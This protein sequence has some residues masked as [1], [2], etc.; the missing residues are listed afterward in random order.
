MLENQMFIFC[1][2]ELFDCYHFFFYLAGLSSFK[3][4]RCFSRWT[5]S[6]D[7]SAIEIDQV[8]ILMGKF[9][10]ECAFDVFPTTVCVLVL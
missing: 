7:C 2:S 9:V 4:D 8:I 6:T 3:C 1:Y 5:E 10:Y